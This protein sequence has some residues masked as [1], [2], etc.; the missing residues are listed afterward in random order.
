MANKL[1]GIMAYCMRLCLFRCSL[2]FKKTAHKIFHQLKPFS[3]MNDTHE[4]TITVN[5]KTYRYDPD[6][7]CYYRLTAAPTWRERFGWSLVLLAMIILCVI[8]V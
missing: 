8:L 7:D 6:F 1:V 2:D 4:Q 3:T 5:G